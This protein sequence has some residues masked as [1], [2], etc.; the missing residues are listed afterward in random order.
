MSQYLF[1]Y[2]PY[3]PSYDELD[4]KISSA[5]INMRTKLDHLTW[6]KQFNIAEASSALN[7]AIRDGRSLDTALKGIVSALKVI[8]SNIA[9]IN[10]ASNR[11]F[12][13]LYFFSSERTA[14][15]R[16]LIE[17]QQSQARLTNTQ[18]TLQEKIRNKYEKI[19]IQQIE[20]DRYRAFNQLEAEAT[21]KAIDVQ[22][23]QLKAELYQVEM[24]KNKVDQDLSKPLEKFVELQSER[25]CIE[26]DISR[27]ETLDKELSNA[28]NGGAKKIIHD[29]CNSDFGEVSPKR[30]IY[31]K[32]KELESIDRKL[33]KLDKRLKN[34]ADISARVIHKL[35]ID[36]NNMCYQ[37]S[38]YKKQF[39]GLSA[40]QAISKK[41]L[42]EYQ[43]V[44][45]FDSDIRRLL[46]MSDQ[47]IQAQFSETVRIHIVASK[48]KADETLLDTAFDKN[49]YVISNDKFDDFPDKK[50]VAENRLIKHEVLEN[51][52]F[53]HDLY[54]SADFSPI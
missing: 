35:V 47:A 53:I 37:N 41:L 11:G 17:Y 1:A 19:G 21:V 49:V 24:L 8:N 39:I 5:L 20:I 25:E 7:N 4:K 50:V 38:S 54:M 44:I 3:S 26:Y 40:L 22:L 29:Q 14:N 12:D 28:T 42:Y 23:I 30:V 16:K 9:N 45:V 15:N 13:V 32:Q 18:N 48:Q 46:N 34:I 36:G 2:N 33:E 31:T 51:K 52:I 27:A 6:Y 10:I 43:I